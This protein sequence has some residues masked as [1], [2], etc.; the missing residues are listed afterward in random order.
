MM[1]V[2]RLKIWTDLEFEKKKI[3]LESYYYLGKARLAK[4]QKFH[5]LVPSIGS[6]MK[7]T[8]R[9]FD[10]SNIST[11]RTVSQAVHIMSKYTFWESECLVKALAAMWMLEKRRIESTLYMGTGKDEEGKLIAHAWLRS[12]PYYIT[13]SEGKENFT[14]VGKFAKNIE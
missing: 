4:Y 6:H 5:K 7:E 12:G 8:N 10:T 2:R 1:L 11:I 13:G 14:I 9:E 3:F